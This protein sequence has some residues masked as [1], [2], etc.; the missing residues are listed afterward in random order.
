MHF[1][2]KF[3]QKMIF[4]HIS[5]HFV[6]ISALFLQSAMFAPVV[7]HGRQVSDMISDIFFFKNGQKRPKT[8]KNGQKR[9]KTAKNGQKW[10][11]TAKKRDFFFFFLLVFSLLCRHFICCSL[12]RSKIAKNGQKWPKTAKNGIF[13]S[14]LVRKNCT[15]PV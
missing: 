14:F 7:G 6:H 8:A 4:L 10:P 12:K 1:L 3:A 13:D 9:P 2:P 15:P 5:A 11:K